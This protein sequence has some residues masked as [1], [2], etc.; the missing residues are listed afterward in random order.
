M[1]YHWGET[2]FQVW[3][4]T[5][6]VWLPFFLNQTC[7]QQ[8]APLCA[9]SSGYSKRNWLYKKLFSDQASKWW[10]QCYCNCWKAKILY[11]AIPSYS[12]FAD[13]KWSNIGNVSLKLKQNN[14]TQDVLTS[15]AFFSTQRSIINFS[16][17]KMFDSWLVWWLILCVNLDGPGYPD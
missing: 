16:T 2:K 11:W 7:P 3:L 15:L 5:A 9:K 12:F 4:Q 17:L 13:Q 14:K 6:W 8:Q 1:V 10:W